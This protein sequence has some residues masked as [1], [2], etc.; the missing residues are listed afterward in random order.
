MQV[1]ASELA[2]AYH[3]VKHNLSYASNDCNV[4]LQSKLFHDSPIAKKIT[5][6]KT[7]CE[8]LVKGVLGPNSLINI[9]ET[10]TVNLFFGVGFDASNKGNRK[11]FPITVRYF[12][13][14]LGVCNKLVD[15]YEDGDESA[16]A[17]SEQ[18]LSRISD[19]GLNLCQVSSFTADNT[20]ANYGK[21]NSV[22]VHLKQR[23]PNLMKS[24]CCAHVVHNAC[25]A[26]MN[27]M[28]FDVELLII[29]VYNYFS[30]SAK[31]V[32]QLKDFFD[33]VDLEYSNLLRHVTTRWLSLK[34]G[35]ERLLQ[36]LTA[37]TSYFAS[38]DDCPNFI[39][40][41][42]LGTDLEKQKLITELHL[43][44]SLHIVE[45]FHKAVL[46]LE[47]NELAVCDVFH[48]MKDLKCQLEHRMRD[49]FF[50][51]RVHQTLDK[52]GELFPNENKMHIKEFERV[53]EVCLNYLKKWFD[54]SENNI[55]SIM[56]C[57][58]L[59]D[60]PEF[61]KVLQLSESIGIIDKL[62]ADE[63]YSELIV[64]SSLF[65]GDT[66]ASLKE[67]MISMSVSDRWVHV[68]DLLGATKLRNILVLVKFILSIFPSNAFTERVFSVMN[69]KWR[70][71]RNRSSISL[72]K[73]ELFTYFNYDESCSEFY[74]KVLTDKKILAKGRS[75][76]KYL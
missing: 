65:S 70:D 21:N 62:N 60:S 48:V 23:N 68:I 69:M 50:G 74:Q 40:K 56:D 53:Y 37:L 42:L 57:I 5:C 7:K 16:V 54:F 1:T 55:F 58:S 35:I 20:N 72:I 3:T 24:N 75:N 8:G 22:Y 17:M 61:Q 63:M 11:C 49:S 2:L 32:A 47:K 66:G 31:R 71:D 12:S 38:I 46:N 39:Q 18:I 67:K 27:V 59:K 44:F 64:I 73:Q 14:K 29:K 76:E 19:L 51:Y 10:L 33:F 13:E 36:N 43:H 4:K 45:L 9:K 52:L 41:H 34:P 26:G 25:R 15:F 6:G 30:N 28:S